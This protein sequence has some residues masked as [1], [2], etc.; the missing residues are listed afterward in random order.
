MNFP[1]KREL[2]NLKT[3]PIFDLSADLNT[4]C[5]PL[6]TATEITYFTHAIH[7]KDGSISTLTTCP[8]WTE[9]FFKEQYYNGLYVV[10]NN[11]SSTTR[12]MLWSALPPSQ[13]LNISSQCFDI[14]N[15]ITLLE[16]EKE[17]CHCYLFA[18]SRNNTQIANFYINNLDIL[19]RFILYYKDRAKE[20]INL[21]IKN[22][23]VTV[24]ETVNN[25]KFVH[26]KIT[27]EQ[28]KMYLEKTPIHNYYVSLSNKTVALSKREMDCIKL[29]RQGKSSAETAELLSISFR[30]VEK[31]IENVK[32]KLEC[33]K[34]SELISKITNLKIYTD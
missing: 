18:T 6:F 9:H 31:H 22:K 8:E 26:H 17:C 2:S 13:A 16:F 25:K 30:T 19:E 32:A 29:I 12:Y 20:I 15:G 23:I 27:D 10:R 14:D 1:L 3:N 4:I 7:F 5:Q 24:T 34:K 28:K 21:A 11:I 33:H